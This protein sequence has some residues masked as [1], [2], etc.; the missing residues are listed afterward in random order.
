[1]RA[2]FPDQLDS[3]DVVVSRIPSSRRVPFDDPKTV[4]EALRPAMPALAK[5]FAVESFA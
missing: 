1:M 2:S 5:S 4:T 3:I